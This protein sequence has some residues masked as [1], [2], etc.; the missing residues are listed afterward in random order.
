MTATYPH[1]VL[2]QEPGLKAQSDAFKYLLILQARGLSI[3]HPIGLNRF[4][5]IPVPE[6]GETLR[7]L[8]VEL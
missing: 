7:K 4:N 2:L 5:A 3:F 8:E 6:I 1:H